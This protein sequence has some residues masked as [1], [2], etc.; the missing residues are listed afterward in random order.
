MFPFWAKESLPLAKVL[1]PDATALS[2]VA[3][4]P[5]LLSIFTENEPTEP[6]VQYVSPV[7]NPFT[8]NVPPVLFPKVAIPFD[9]L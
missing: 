2:P 9:P 7:V 1:L 6:D 5:E 8:L 3:S 4:N